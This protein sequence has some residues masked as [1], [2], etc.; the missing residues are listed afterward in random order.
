[1]KL[2]TIKLATFVYSRI[3]KCLQIY[4]LSLSTD[5]TNNVVFKWKYNPVSSFR[6]LTYCIHCIMLQY[7]F[8]HRPMGLCWDEI[9][10][11]SIYETG[12]Y[13]LWW[14]MVSH[15]SSSQLK[16]QYTLKPLRM[17]KYSITND[18]IEINV[19]SSSSM[20]VMDIFR[21]IT[22]T[23]LIFDIISDTNFVPHHLIFMRWKKRI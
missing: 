3:W 4:K 18:F 9:N 1:M 17:C 12:T 16:T 21:Q 5:V 2:L 14:Y 11:L 23:C 22:Y 13:I 20:Y 10:H 15:K 19:L 6:H 8:A 7:V